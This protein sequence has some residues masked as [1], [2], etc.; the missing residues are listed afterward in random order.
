[1][2]RVVGEEIQARR[3]VKH[4][5]PGKDQGGE[6]DEA[7]GEEGSEEEEE[8]ANATPLVRPGTD[9]GGRG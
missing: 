5:A 8:R 6:E 4:F 2:G 7:Q 1:M 9:G 3:G